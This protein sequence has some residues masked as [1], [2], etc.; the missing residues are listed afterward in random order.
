M[1]LYVVQI[2]ENVLITHD[3]NVQLGIFY[4]SL[5]NF[6]TLQKSDYIETYWIP[7]PMSK[8]YKRISYQKHL[9]SNGELDKK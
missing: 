5:E 1:T 9:R 8:R 6:M 4:T 3:G 7:D 2:K